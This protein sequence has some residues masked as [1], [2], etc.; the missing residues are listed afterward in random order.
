MTYTQVVLHSLFK[1]QLL[2]YGIVDINA[3]IYI[4]LI[5]IHLKCSFC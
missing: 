2:Q 5:R 4:F 1:L 3:K